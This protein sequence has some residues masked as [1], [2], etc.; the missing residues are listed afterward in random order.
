MRFDSNRT[1]N[2]GSNRNMTKP[3]AQHP[4]PKRKLPTSFKD[5]TPSQHFNPRTFFRELVWK[6]LLTRRS[7][8]HKFPTFPNLTAGQVAITWIGHASFL[9][10][11]TDLN[12]LIDPNFANWLFLLKRIKRSGLKIE[13]VLFGSRE[14]LQLAGETQR[15][16]LAAG[17]EL[18]A[19][20]TIEAALESCSEAPGQSERRSGTAVI[21]GRGTGAAG[22]PLACGWVSIA[23]S[24][25]TIQRIRTDQQGRYAIDG[26]PPGVNSRDAVCVP[27]HPEPFTQVTVKPADALA[28]ASN[29]SVAFAD[30][31]RPT[32]IGSS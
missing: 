19:Q 9:V 10:Q 13:D 29:E 11:F 31:S 20:F 2:V 4:A 1:I 32:W 22:E 23:K 27:E 3:A 14:S 18:E 6:A 26:V 25:A 17:D 30:A 16:T 24:S 8:Q 28:S 7:G 5:L 15:V 21:Q 12:V